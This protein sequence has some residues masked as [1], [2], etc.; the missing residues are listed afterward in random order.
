MWGKDK[1]K[2]GVNMRKIVILI[3]AVIILACLGSIGYGSWR[4]VNLKTQSDYLHITRVEKSSQT[5]YWHSVDDYRLL[6]T[7][8]VTVNSGS[9]NIDAG[10][11][12][13]VISLFDSNGQYNTRQ[14]DDLG[15][16]TRGWEADYS[17]TFIIDQNYDS[18]QYAEVILYLD[19]KQVDNAA[20]HF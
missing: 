8:K 9:E 17:L 4:L 3:C 6:W 13:L 5:I 16:L 14:K 7:I 20:I 1:C 10:R 12:K 15:P 18:N 11:T 19:G 2:K